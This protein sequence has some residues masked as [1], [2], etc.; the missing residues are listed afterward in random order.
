[1]YVPHDTDP[2][3]DSIDPGSGSDRFTGVT[4][5]V[6]PQASF[7]WRY[8]F[9]HQG[10]N[11]TQ[12]FQP[13]AQLVLSPNCCNTGKIPNEDSRTFEWDDT[14]V[15]S[16]DR[17]S[18]YDRVDG[19]SRLNYGLEWSAYNANGG[20]AE[21][22]LGQSYQFLRSHDEPANTGIDRTLTD[23]VGRLT[24][25]PGDFLDAT[26]RFRFNVNAAKMERQEVEFIVGPPELSL[27]VGYVQLAG[28]DV[29]GSREQVSGSVSTK[30][31]DYWS[32]SAGASY[33]LVGTR[34]NGLN[35]AFGYND[36]CFG[37]NLSAQYS[38]QGNTDISSGKFAAFITFSFKNLGDIGTSF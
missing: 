12:V 18:G 36:E 28:N 7:K 1:M 20:R 25:E 6:F 9:V 5:R 23:V 14:K 10:E 32:A 34:I 17:F 33:D 21:A 8:P 22:F 38:P 11:F 2:N 35:A 13:I 3:S 29:F 31:Y 30:L 19:G 37:M 15:F 27:S 24:L 26:Y 4:G 16:A